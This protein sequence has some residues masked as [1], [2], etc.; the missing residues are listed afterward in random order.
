MNSDLDVIVKH[1]PYKT[2][3]VYA[4]GDIHIGSQ[5]FDERAV[6]RKLSIIQ[7]DDEAALVLCGDVA[8]FGLKNSRSNVY[9]Q[10]MPVKDQIEY[11][12]ELLKPVAHKMSAVVPGNHE[13]RV[14][15]EVGLC[16]LYD[17]CVRWGVPE[18][19]RENMAI[20]KYSFGNKHN[21]R[22]IVIIGLTTHGSTRNKHQRFISCFDADIAIS[23]HIHHGYYQQHARVAVDRINTT[24][25]IVPFHELVVDANLSVGGY[26][27]KHEYEIPPTPTLQYFELSF[28]RESNRSRTEHKIINYHTIQ[29]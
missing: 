11:A 10:V 6:K 1:Y 21:G 8:D 23:G 5:E 12:Y 19:Y 15:K 28:Y 25:R 2:L 20:T 16:P 17:L 22:P 29:I 3:R 7:D 13:E 14:T 18:V 4:L 26:G 27:V 24:A 9:Q